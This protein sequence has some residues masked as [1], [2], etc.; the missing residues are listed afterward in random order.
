[1]PIVVWIA[2]TGSFVDCQAI[3]AA[4]CPMPSIAG[5]FP[6][7]WQYSQT[8]DYDITPYGGFIANGYWEPTKSPGIC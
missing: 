7:I 5:Y 1:M 8:P 6:M 3:E 2:A 4:Y